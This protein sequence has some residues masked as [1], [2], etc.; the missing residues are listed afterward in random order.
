MVDRVKMKTREHEMLLMCDKFYAQ[1]FLN[2]FS[3]NFFS[4]PCGQT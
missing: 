2:V 1:I 4:D 3:L